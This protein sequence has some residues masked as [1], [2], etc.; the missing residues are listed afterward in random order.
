MNK[1]MYIICPWAFLTVDF[2]TWESIYFHAY[3]AIPSQEKPS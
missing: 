2:N 3:R 1:S